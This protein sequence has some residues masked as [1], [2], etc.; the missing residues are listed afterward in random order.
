MP[1]WCTN[2][3]TV[4]G[5]NED[6]E[7]FREAA[8][9]KLVEGK[10]TAFSLQELVPCPKELYEVKSGFADLAYDVKYGD[11]KKVAICSWIRDANDGLVP[12]SREEAIKIFRDL[13]PETMADADRYKANLE[14]HGARDWYHWCCDNWGTKWNVDA[15][16]DQLDGR[17]IYHFES[18]WAPPLNA[19]QT[20][21]S[22]YPTLEFSIKF[23]EEGMEFVGHYI[24]LAGK[25]TFKDEGDFSELNRFDF[26]PR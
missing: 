10:S 11:W 9:G 17:L 2:K 26:K 20:I 1:N 5:L 8:G 13:R 16:V 7:R 19:L 15:K 21:S 24:F 6:L 3:L 18:A 4:S 25:I 23:Y 14:K 22:E 12:E